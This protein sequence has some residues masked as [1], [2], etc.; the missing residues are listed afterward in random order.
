[1]VTRSP[2]CK[3]HVPVCGTASIPSC[4]IPARATPSATA[5]VE[6]IAPV[7]GMAFAPNDANDAKAAAG[8]YAAAMAVPVMAACAIDA[9]D[10]VEPTKSC[11]AW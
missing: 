10:D 3:S 5:V 4:A 6:R 8:A 7:A 9:A 11:T 1:M 2:F